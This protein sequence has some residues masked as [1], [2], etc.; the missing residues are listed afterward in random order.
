MSS[1]CSRYGRWQRASESFRQ[2]LFEEEDAAAAVSA[3]VVEEEEE[4]KK[5]ASKRSRK[6]KLREVTFDRRSV[7]MASA[8]SVESRAVTRVLCIRRYLARRREL[9]GGGGWK[10]ETRKKTS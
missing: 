2:G 1:L 5:E 3:A 9:D 4:E 10:R 6:K 8:D 7:K